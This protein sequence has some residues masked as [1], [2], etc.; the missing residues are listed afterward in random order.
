[1]PDHVGVTVL[2]L[3]LDG[4]CDFCAGTLETEDLPYHAC[5]RHYE[6][7]KK[8]LEAENIPTADIELHK[9]WSRHHPG[10]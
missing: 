9:D 10:V 8:V 1:M 7:M 3:I 4:P 5:E 6:E 2:C